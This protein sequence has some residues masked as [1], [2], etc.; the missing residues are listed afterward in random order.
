MAPDFVFLLACY[1]SY[2]YVTPHVF[3]G[4]VNGERLRTGGLSY[5]ASSGYKR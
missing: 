5:S 1:S 4:V 2:T 3:V